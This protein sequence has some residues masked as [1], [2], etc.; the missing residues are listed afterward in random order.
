MVDSLSLQKT[1]SQD[2]FQLENDDERATDRNKS[3]RPS[4]RS[5][6]NPKRHSTYENYGSGSTIS[7]PGKTS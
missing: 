5:S 2:K 3:F 7:M 6:F 4:S 1:R